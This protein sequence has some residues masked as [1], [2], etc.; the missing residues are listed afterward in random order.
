M[1]VNNELERICDEVATAYF[2]VLSQ[3]I[4]AETYDNPS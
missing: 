1:R 4:F 3:H 2:N